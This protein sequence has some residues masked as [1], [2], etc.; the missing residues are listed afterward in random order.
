MKSLIQIALLSLLAVPAAAI[1]KDSQGTTTTKP[2]IDDDAARFGALEKVSSVALSA[3]GKKFVYIA[4]GAGSGTVAAVVDLAALTATPAAQANGQPMNLS[5]C[6]W[7]AA[8]RLVCN[9]YGVTR[10]DALLVPVTRT[11]A[12]DADG[13][14]V[15]PL[16]QRNSVNQAD[17]RQFDGA[18]VD[19]LN[20]VDGTVLMSRTY[21]PEISMGSRTARTEEGLG[22]DRIDTR[23]GKATRLETPNMAAVEFVSDGLG[24]IRIMTT[25]VTDSA[26]DLRGVNN[27][28]Y[29]TVG[30]RDWQ[31]LG[32]DSGGADSIVPLAVD[33]IINSAYVL[34]SLDGRQALFR[35]ALDGSLKKELVFASKEVDV[36]GVI[37][38]GR[39]GRVIGASYVT[40]RRQVE[41]FDPA[42][43]SIAASLALALPNLP[44]I[45]FV[46]ASADEQ[47][48]FV[49]AGSDVDPGHNYVFDRVKSSLVEVSR[50]RPDLKGKT[51]SA[52]K[53]VTYAAADGTQIP[54]FLTLP[55]GVANAKGL[56]AIVM[57]HGGPSSRD[58]WGFD[59]LAQFFAQRGFAVLQPNFRGSAGY[60][61]D[62]FLNN[63]F[64]S[65]KTSVGD[66]CD[67]ARWL[68][69]QGI[70]DPDKLAVF[71]WSYG[72][73]AALQAN[74]VDPSLFRAVVAVAPVTD[75]ALFKDEA[76]SYT[77]A[78]VVADFVGSGPHVSEGSPAQNA[79]AFKS[80]VLMFHGDIDL[81]VNIEQSRKMNKALR[82]A[83]KSSELVVY[84]N[85]DHSL[86]DGEVRADMLRKSEAFL[87]DKLKM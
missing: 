86:R 47:V 62:W 41:Y 56:P 58:E 50:S 49:W 13:H 16:G 32:T 46:S 21:V 74:V 20:G 11:V 38:V 72:G 76:M 37:R 19:W 65:W 83:G 22:V 87:R 17:I 80:S 12:M 82:S 40:D 36:A 73:Y 27:H 42:Y 35:I 29:R 28:F 43:R 24:N 23:T 30:S 63:G 59:W 60:G 57:P 34:Q 31:K 71:G 51:L 70:A 75:L 7:S 67:G 45:R 18:I 44:M 33:P 3:D 54:A 9:L 68:K 55:P 8:D 10:H 66:V 64:Q 6:D 61:D 15:L 69:E 14:N 84:P 79:A 52:V 48:L 53:S 78:R 4:P 81:N 26:G 25:T 1:A 2:A 77:S 5:D 85:L 39:G